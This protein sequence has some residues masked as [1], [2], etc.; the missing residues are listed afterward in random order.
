MFRL[1]G[2]IFRLFVEPY[3]RYIKYSAH[4]GIP[5]SLHLKI[6]VKLLQYYCIDVLYI[7]FELVDNCQ[8]VQTINI[9]HK[10]NNTVII[11]LVS[12]NVNFWDPRMCAVLDVSTIWFNE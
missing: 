2:V 4:S 12:L 11:L 9:I 8:P 3:R 6:Q 10:Y 7:S 1:E 5:K